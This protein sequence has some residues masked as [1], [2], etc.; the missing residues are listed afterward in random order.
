MA[1]APCPLVALQVHSPT[2]MHQSYLV[3]PTVSTAGGHVVR[4]PTHFYTPHT[5]GPNIP[6][7]HPPAVPNPL[8]PLPHGP[9]PPTLLSPSL[10]DGTMQGTVLAPAVDHAVPL[11][12]SVVAPLAQQLGHLSLGSAGTVRTPPA[13]T[14][15]LPPPPAPLIPPAPPV[16]A[17]CCPAWSLPPTVPP[18]AARG[19]TGG[20]CWGHSRGGG[21]PCSAAGG[22]QPLPN[23]PTGR[24][25]C[26]HPRPRPRGV[27]L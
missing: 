24:Q 18:C 8:C 1:A 27:A 5:P 20:E 26:T 4:T 10:A 12:P 21:R 14:P 15:P 2:W 16:R 22:S 9:A 11:Q 13:A 6:A 7:P 3:Q 19:A 17:R 23:C 25:R